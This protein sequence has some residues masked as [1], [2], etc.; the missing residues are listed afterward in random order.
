VVAR[1]KGVTAVEQRIPRDPL[2][3]ARDGL[4]VRALGRWEWE[5]EQPFA[6]R[7]RYVFEE[8]HDRDGGGRG[9]LAVVARRFKL[10]KRA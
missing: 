1:F 7:Y 9:Y 2:V 4:T 10:L 5:S 3:P 6:P 8:Y